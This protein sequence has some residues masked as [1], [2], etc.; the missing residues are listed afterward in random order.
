MREIAECRRARQEPQPWLSRERGDRLRNPLCGGG[1]VDAC[2]RT[3]EQRAA[4]L[5]L[6][7]AED[8][9]CAGVCRGQRRGESRRPRS[10]DQHV[11]VRVSMRIAIGVW[12]WRRAAE[13]R[14]RADQRL[15]ETRPAGARPHESLVVEAGRKQR[16]QEIVEAAHV[17]V[18]ARP[19]VLGFRAEAVVQLDLGGAEIRRRARGIAAHGDECARLLGAGRQ[20]AARPVVLERP[21]DQ[22]DAVGEQR[23]SERVALQALECPAV[24]GEL[25]RVRAVDPA[26][27]RRAKRVHAGGL[28]PIR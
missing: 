2:W 20:D 24:E 27:A 26:A 11:A 3:G 1:A 4:G 17:E 6:F 28:S 13:S 9:A 12:Q 15:V 19:A 8:H 7:V 14:R 21:P 18:E 10:D 25:Q 5:R 22:V 23:G 16:R